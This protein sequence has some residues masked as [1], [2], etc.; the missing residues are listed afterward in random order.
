PMVENN[1]EISADNINVPKK[2]GKTKGQV[3]S[4]FKQVLMIPQLIMHTLMTL[5]FSLGNGF[6]YALITY[7]MIYTAGLTA[8]EQATVWSFSSIS[9]Y[10]FLFLSIILVNLIGSRRLVFVG[11]FILAAGSSFYYY[12]QGLNG[13]TALVVF[14]VLFVAI[15]SPFWAMW[16]NIS[17]DIADIDEF[18]YG[19]RRTALVA[20]ISMFMVKIGPTVSLITTGLLLKAAG[21]VEGGSEQ[22]PEVGEALGG[23]ITLL[24]GIFFA[25]GAIAFCRY[26]I[27]RKNSSALN[28]A[29]EKRRNGE[30]YST[31]GFK[32]LLP[33]WYKKEHNIE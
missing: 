2:E 31:E 19:K 15:E 27:N 28:E 21:Y 13:L 18:L 29:L 14:M 11:A 8:G 16:F 24:S 32:E 7:V 20:S 12:F 4:S 1:A 9:N 26:N 10:A 5:C 30:S 17:F 33:K 22:I 23:Y 25:L 6:R 3:W